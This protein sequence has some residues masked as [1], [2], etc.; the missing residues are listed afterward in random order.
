[1]VTSMAKS[2]DPITLAKDL[3]DEFLSK[4][5]PAATPKPSDKREKAKAA[6]R[7]GGLKREPARAAK[8]SPKKR[9]TIAQ[10]GGR[11]RQSKA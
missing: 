4:A 10:K 11:V 7:L 1:M 8:L 3:F 5:D 2:K 9:H 6:G